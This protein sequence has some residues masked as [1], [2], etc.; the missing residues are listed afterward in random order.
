V[1]PERQTLVGYRLQRAR[2]ALE[3]ARILLDAGHVNGCVSR[4]YYACFYGV[5]ALLLTANMAASTHGYIRALLHRDYVKTGRISEQMGKHFDVLFNNQEKADHEDLI[6]FDAAIVRSW[7][8]STKAFV[9]QIAD[10]IA[11]QTA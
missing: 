4:L 6:V 11:R 2:E 8:E 1:T 3:E 9:D 10:L 5:S 7:F